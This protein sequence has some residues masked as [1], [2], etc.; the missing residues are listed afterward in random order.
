MVDRRGARRHNGPFLCAP[1]VHR[2]VSGATSVRDNRL[3]WN[4]RSVAD[5]I[6]VNA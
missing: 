4:E 2:A 5:R 3:G 6:G 1:S